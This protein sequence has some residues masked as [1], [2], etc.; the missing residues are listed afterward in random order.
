MI[1]RRLAAAMAEQNWFTVMLELA[2]VIFGIIIALQ[3]NDWVRERDERK[4]EAAAL[5]RLLAEAEN[6]VA[7]IDRDVV[8]ADQ[9]NEARRQAVAVVDG[10]SEIPQDDLALRVG[11]NTMVNTPTMTPAR[12]TYDE[13]TSAGQMQLIRSARIR[14]Q[15]ALYYAVLDQ[16]R[17]TVETLDT[18]N[19]WEGYFRHVTYRYNAEST[20]SDVVLSTYDWESLRADGKFK[21]QLIGALRNQLRFQG[22]RRQLLFRARAMCDA[23]AAEVGRSCQ[24]RLLADSSD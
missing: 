14:D 19:F 18:A 4:L 21:S 9:L 16:F 12:T 6:A 3:V 17:T 1:M 2:I 11:I 13:L 7:Y 10:Q 5:Q 22:M 15:I 24:P 8:R 20:T 23:I